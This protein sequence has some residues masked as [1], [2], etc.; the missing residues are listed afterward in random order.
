[1]NED[2]CDRLDKWIIVKVCWLNEDLSMDKLK[3]YKYRNKSAE[4]IKPKVTDKL[5]ESRLKLWVSWMNEDKCDRQDKWMIF[6][7][8]SMLTE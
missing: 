2:E 5:N 4:W 8:T 3:E 6:T 7:V 1:M